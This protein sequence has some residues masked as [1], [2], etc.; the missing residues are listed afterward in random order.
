MHGPR[1]YGNPPKKQDD[2]QQ[3]W[4][5]VVCDAFPE[6]TVEHKAKRRAAYAKAINNGQHPLSHHSDTEIQHIAEKFFDLT[7]M[8]LWEADKA[9]S[10]K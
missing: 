7:A 9:C 5:L 3:F 2:R 10:I 4:W 8:Q 1:W 6:N